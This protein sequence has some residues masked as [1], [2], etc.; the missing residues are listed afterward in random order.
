[1]KL[2]STLNVFSAGLWAVAGAVS[3][4]GWQVVRIDTSTTDEEAVRSKLS[5]VSH[6]EWNATPNK[7]I[8]IA[9]SPDDVKQLSSLGFQYEI[10]HQ[11]LGASIST[12]SKLIGKW[13]RQTDDLSWFQSYHS[14]EEHR[15]YFEA[16]HAAFPNNSEFVSTGTSYEGRDIWGL[17][18]WGAHGPGQ[19]A[20]LW[21]GTVHAREWITA[22]VS[23]A[24]VESVFDS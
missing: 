14:Y 5:A 8:T 4:D 11:D 23:Q 7:D 2:I 21:H 17:H 16:L 24:R 1:M 10:L 3:Y 22:M 19:P 18:F 20:V 6:D 13:K 9:A 15:Q 12:E